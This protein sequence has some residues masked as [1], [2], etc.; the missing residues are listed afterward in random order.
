LTGQYP[1]EVSGSTLEALQNIQKTEPIRPRQ[2]I[3]KFDSDVEAILL[4]ALAKEPSKR[5]HSAPDLKSDIEH[6]LEGRPIR[7]K[8]ISTTYL[9]RKII[10]RH[11]YTSTVAALL[12]LIIIGFAFVCFD[13]YITAKKERQKSDVIAKQWEAQAAKVPTLNRRLTFGNFMDMW[14]AGLI[15]E[16]KLLTIFYLADGSKEKNA[17]LFLLNPNSLAQ[18]EADFRKSLSDDYTGFADLIIG[19]HHLKAGNHNEAIKAYQDSHATIQQSRQRNLT[20]DTWVE[21]KIKARLTELNPADKPAGESEKQ[22]A[23]IL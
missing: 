1:Y 22:K 12:L 14:H 6:W 8:C 7:V 18:K 20:V 17:A 15:N 23:G 10:A 13:L 5:Y 19:E 9:L 11:R 3:R 4:T 16:A 21:T 2:I